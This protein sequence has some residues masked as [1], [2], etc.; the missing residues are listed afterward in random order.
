MWTKSFWKG[1]GERAIKTF[2]Q[3]LVAVVTLGAG[4]DAIGVSAGIADVSWTDAVSVALLA[5]VLSLAT[6]IGN[7]EFTAGYGEPVGRR[8]LRD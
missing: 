1:A 5:T 6:S 8:A 7:S 3:T 2:F 4:A